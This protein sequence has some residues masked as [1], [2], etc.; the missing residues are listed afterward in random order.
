MQMKLLNIL[1]LA[2]LLA[3]NG[4]SASTLAETFTVN[5]TV[6]DATTGEVLIGATVSV[7]GT[8]TGV[9]TNSYGFYSLTLLAGTVTLQARYLGYDVLEQTVRLDKHL[10]LDLKMI[11]SA[12]QLQVVEVKAKRDEAE[13]IVRSPQ[14]SKIDLNVTQ[15]KTMP[16]LLGERDLVKAL[17]LMPGVKRGGEGQTGM[18][19]R[20]GGPDQNLILLDEATVYNI[21]HMLGFFSVFSTESLKE[22]SLI[23]GGFPANY[24]GRLSSIMDVR[25]KEGNMQKFHG[26]GGIGIISSRLMLEGPIV[27]E[28]A[29]FLVSGRRTYIDKLFSLVGVPLPYYFYDLNG[30]VNYKISE[31]D[32]LYL[33]AY[34]GNDVLTEPKGMGEEEFLNFGFASGNLTT[35]LRWNRIINEKTFRNV[36]LIHT[37]FR[38]AVDGKIDSN[39]IFVSSKIRDLGLKID[40]N[41]YHSPVLTLQYG[42]QLTQHNFRPNIINSEGEISEF[43]KEKEGLKLNNQEVALY[44]LGEWKLTDALT[45]NGGLR[46]SGLVAKEKVYAG[47]EPRLAL[48]YAFNPIHS[49]KASYSRMYQYLHQVSNSSVAL[50]TDLWY[51]VTERVEPLSSDQVA[52]SYTVNLKPLKSLLTVEAYYKWMR[53]LVEYREGAQLIL[54]DN[55]EDE[56]VT[57]TG[58]GYGVE[59]F[60]HKR[61]GRLNGWIGYT[62]SWSERQFDELN[63]GK[64]FFAK[65]DR[66]H[67][68]STVLNWEISKR[69]T[70]STVWVYATGSRF[71]A[72]IGQYMMPSPTF[73][74]VEVVPIYSDRNAVVLSPSH[75]L[76]VNL[77][78][79]NK[80]HKKFRSEW[81]FGAYNVYNRAQPYRVRVN[82]E[83][84]KYEQVGLFGFIPSIA[85]NFAF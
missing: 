29:S 45:L 36:S 9:S 75:R 51:P 49:V 81:H 27:K 63:E 70:F 61:E 5:G 24:G 2:F 38:Y 18:Y 84:G 73:D 42:G 78:L 65:Y 34:Y 33:S 66:R 22:V 44:G 53:N 79:K 12:T 64:P 68:L 83:T 80:P 57:G 14:M 17:Q 60:L 47:P 62:L 41:Y 19:V 3:G 52:A 23:K 28:K 11:P 1:F 10:K 43:V 31:R 55:Y 35:T 39:S 46:L 54:N 74:N 15:V 56:L 30:K 25:M 7:A 76:D 48:A 20:G 6:T 58:R 59:L 8:T 26:E 40:Y 82:M 77:V 71:T 16:T 72:I 21:N 67:D 85:W 4:L 13:E 37:R 32:R 69:F 50:P